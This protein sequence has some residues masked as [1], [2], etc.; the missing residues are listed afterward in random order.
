ME[1][2]KKPNQ[3]RHNMSDQDKSWAYSDVL[4]DLDEASAVYGDQVMKS[5]E[6]KFQ[7][8]R[9]QHIAVEH[10]RTETIDGLTQVVGDIVGTQYFETGSDTAFIV[11]ESFT[12]TPNKNYKGIPGQG[13]QY[14]ERYWAKVDPSLVWG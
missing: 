8:A 12:F 3:E 2:T 5:V 4:I 11:A 13:A 7:V 10:I 14:Q 6:A 9:V 1:L